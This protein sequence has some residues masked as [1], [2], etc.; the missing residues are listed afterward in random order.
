MSASTRRWLSESELEDG[1]PACAIEVAS[2]RRR[3]GEPKGTVWAELRQESRVHLGPHPPNPFDSQARIDSD[4][5]NSA[6]RP[7]AWPAVATCCGLRRSLCLTG[8][9]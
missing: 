8:Q 1:S 5:A 6:G 9:A 2:A 7:R 3:P 4:A